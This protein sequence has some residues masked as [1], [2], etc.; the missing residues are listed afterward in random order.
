MSMGTMTERKYEAG[1][2][3]PL[4]RRP[5]VD[6][7][8]TAGDAVTAYIDDQIDRLRAGE[9]AVRAR[10][11]DGVHDMRVAVR[12]LRSTLRTFRPVI[13]RHT[14]VSD[15]LKWLS[16]LLGGAR[17]A[18]VLRARLAAKLDATPSELVLG[19]VHAEL[20]RQLARPESDVDAALRSAL[21]GDRYAALVRDLTALAAGRP[22]G[23][24][25]ADRADRVLPKLVG[26]ALR[27]TRRA[28]DAAE[29]ATPGPD[30]DAALHRVRKA[31]KRV[32]Y[33]SEVAAPVIGKQADRTRKRAKRVQDILG[34]HHDLVELRTSL[35]RTGIQ[36][37]MDGTNAFT[38]GLL[39]GSAG[40]QARVLERRFPQAWRKLTKPKKSRWTTS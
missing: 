36:A 10:E 17:D 6:S 19:P 7:G 22:R 1:P 27:R 9:A 21:N 38:F 34:D 8:S 15:E 29:R 31:V 35:R 20:D 28:V 26:K 16:D 2:L 33:A 14:H 24:K 23:R 4:P 12:R 39:H 11:P 5:E 25:A 32:R 40:E 3:M 18:E 37:H 30:R 13:G